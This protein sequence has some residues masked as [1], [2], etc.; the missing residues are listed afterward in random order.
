[1]EQINRSVVNGLIA[2]VL[3][4]CFGI[5]VQWLYPVS[6]SKNESE[7]RT[8][9]DGIY[10]RTYKS[11]AGVTNTCRPYYSHM[12]GQLTYGS[13]KCDGGASP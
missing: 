2:L 3:I 4:A 5:L 9:R 1:M 13:Q 11:D 6:E 8:Y 7:P 12:L 10:E